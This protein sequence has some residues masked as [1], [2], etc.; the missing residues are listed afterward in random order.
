MTRLY[1]VDAC[2]GCVM[3]CAMRYTEEKKLD[4]V[5]ERER[6]SHCKAFVQSKHAHTHTNTPS[7]TS[8]VS[9]SRHTFVRAW[10]RDAA[11]E[12]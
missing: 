2:T 6:I 5:R 10:V 8:G 11:T 7:H 1:E 12:K 4:A 9:Q 3:A